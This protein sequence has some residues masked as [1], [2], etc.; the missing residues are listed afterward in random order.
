V[1]QTDHIAVSDLGIFSPH[2]SRAKQVVKYEKFIAEEVPQIKS[3][4]T[5]KALQGE[6]LK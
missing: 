4:L 2:V 5:W 3:M 1:E 6:D